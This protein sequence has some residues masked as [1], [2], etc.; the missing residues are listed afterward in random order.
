VLVTGPGQR[1]HVIDAGGTAVP[2]GDRLIGI[3]LTALIAIVTVG[4]LTMIAW[5]IDEIVTWLI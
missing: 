1:S 5:L 4:W 3:S 2:F